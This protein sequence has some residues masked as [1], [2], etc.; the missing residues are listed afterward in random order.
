MDVRGGDDLL[1]VPEAAERLKVSAVTVSRWIKQGRLR[2]LKVG[3]RAVRIRTEDLD[4]IMAPTGAP[5]ELDPE[6]GATGPGSGPPINRSANR[7]GRWA[8]TAVN[9]SRGDRLAVAREAQVL[10][11]KIL[12]R[13]KGVALPAPDDAA[14]SGKKRRKAA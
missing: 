6:E 11:E 9:G 12:T 8:V 14:G 1:T 5:V 7:S 4:R 13:R 3:P 2:A 10:R